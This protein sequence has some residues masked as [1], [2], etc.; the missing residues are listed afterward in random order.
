MTRRHSITPLFLLAVGIALVGTGA[1]RADEAADREKGAIAKQA[2]AFV[3]AFHKGDAQALASFWTPDGD[4]VHLSGRV[5]K[6]RQA[7]A[8]EFSELF[9]ENK[10]LTLRIE[11]ASVR[12]PTPDTAI[13][14]G[15]TSVMAR[16]G[17][18]PS[19]TRYS[20]LLVKG[21]GE[22]LIESVREAPF[23]P[24]SNYDHL[25]PLE[26]AIGEWVQET[27]DP[28]VAR[29]L[30][31][32]TP[33]QN[34]IIA[35]RAVGVKD[36]LLDNGHQRIGWDPAAR[37]IRSWSFESDGGFGHGAWKKEGENRWVI[38][39]SSV[40]RDGSLMTSAT[41]VTRVDADTITWQVKDQQ[42]NGKAMPDSP[43]I[44]MKRVK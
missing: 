13:E 12:F 15:V 43:P 25:R 22:W 33:D 31:E 26:W 20:N 32:W 8:R 36:V 40:L 1:V 2:Q 19:R 9:A 23:E 44:T 14:D 38:T 11:V 27:K 7:I 28:H 39:M 41:A 34:F 35:T 17:G 10:G 42:V 37:L 5:I 18:V 24:P 3:E 30:F 6:G 16:E 4:Y 29:V 21:D